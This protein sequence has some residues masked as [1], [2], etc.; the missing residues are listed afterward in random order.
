V[1]KTENKSEIQAKRRFDRCSCLAVIVKSSL[2]TYEWVLSAYCYKYI[3]IF[4]KFLIDL[5]MFAY[6]F[7]V[8]CAID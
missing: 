4:I 1:Y 6:Y 8:F 2:K 7:T 3:N 5:N